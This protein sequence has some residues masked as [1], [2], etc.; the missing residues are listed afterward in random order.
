MSLPLLALAVCAFA[1]GTTEFVVN[2]LQTQI[3]SDVGVSIPT[4]GLL[5]SGFAVGIIVGAPLLAVLGL[6]VGRRTLL[7]AAMALFVAANAIVALA[8][9]YGPLLAGRVLNGVAVGGFYGIASVVAA[10][11]VPPERQARAI[12]L[13]FAGAT[14]G[15]TLGVPIGTLVGQVAGWRATFAAVAVIGVAGIA[16]IA[17]LVPTPRREQRRDLRSELSVL[18]RPQV[19]LALVVTAASFGAITATYAYIEPL[20]RN[21]SGF[22]PRGV[23]LVLLLLGAGLL[24]GGIVGG[25][26]AD[27]AVLP[28]L[29][30]AFAV[31]AVVQVVFGLVAHHQVA[32]AVSAFLFGAAGYALV[33]GAQL[34]VVATA[35]DAPTLAS[36][37]NISAFN[38]GVALGGW[39]AGE[40]IDAGLGYPSV[41]WVGAL[42]AGA[43]LTLV[44]A[45]AALDARVAKRTSGSGE[46]SPV[47]RV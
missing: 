29:G 30:V 36:A 41:T 47:L 18:R 1:I 37:V 16:A 33:P 32:A 12:A 34:R 3:A 38:V 24:L 2:G 31:L 14:A 13:M 19:L 44:L 7:L 5:V 28:A 17:A 10:G 20:L 15:T 21:V 11:L 43:G 4:A 46:G 26:A 9:S 6:R 23:A 8:P 45:S 40:S 42:I 25:R 39:V 22:S 35:A 27:R